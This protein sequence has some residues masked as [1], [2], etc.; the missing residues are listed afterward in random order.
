[1]NVKGALT[2]STVEAPMASGKRGASTRMPAADAAER[3]G[4]PQ[5]ISGQDR[6]ARSGE[7]GGHRAANEG[8]RFCLGDGPGHYVRTAS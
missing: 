4:G 5:K 3:T 8:R 1:M 2:R 7:E 6:T